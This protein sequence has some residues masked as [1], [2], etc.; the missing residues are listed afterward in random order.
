MHRLKSSIILAALTASA[1]A[2]FAQP[3]PPTP[4]DPYPLPVPQQPPPPATPTTPTTDDAS[5]P[6]PTTGEELPPVKKPPPPADDYN[7]DKP[8]P[9]LPDH[10]VDSPVVLTTPTGWLL[11][12]AVLYSKTSIDTAGGVTSD[13][14]FGLGDVA[15]FGLATTDEV[16]ARPDATSPAER[17]QPYLAASF[18]IGVAENRLFAHQPGVTLGFVKSFERNHDDQRT[19]FAAL[20]LVASEHLGKRVAV[21]AGGG[22]WDASIAS[23]APDATDA[24]KQAF[25]FHDEADH[26][27]K[28]IRAF[29]GIQIEPIDKSMIL[30][31][32]GWAPEFCYACTGDDRIK[33]RPELSWGVRYQVADWLQIDSG[34][35]VPDIGSA[36]LLDAQIFG[37]LTFTSWGLRHAVDSLKSDDASPASDA[38]K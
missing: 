13:N 20:S 23:T 34:V 29:G 22:F 15:E 30:V 38:A 31:D 35:R 27:H 11:P 10:L 36:N 18:R 37:G 7:P 25:A 1:A 28:Q 21:H 6:P 8:K 26:W 17:I 5:P 3:A 12:A 19:K 16:R 9:K 32:L 33:L 14:R 2:A 24:Q 4:T